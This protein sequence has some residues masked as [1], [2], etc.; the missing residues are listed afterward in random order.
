MK[1][2]IF[3]ILFLSKISHWTLSHFDTELLQSE[4]LCSSPAVENDLYIDC[5]NSFQP[6]IFIFTYKSYVITNIILEWQNWTFPF[7]AGV[8][9]V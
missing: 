9:N 6:V 1:L 2:I 5:F 8:H 4:F 3:L 7:S